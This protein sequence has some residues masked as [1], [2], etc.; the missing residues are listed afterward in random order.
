MRQRMG[1]RSARPTLRALPTRLLVWLER[2]RAPLG[3]RVADIASREGI[4]RWRSG[5]RVHGHFIPF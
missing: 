4:R 1:I 3:E 5:R 2:R